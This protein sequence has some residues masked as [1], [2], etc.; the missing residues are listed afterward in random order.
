MAL[1]KRATILRTAIRVNLCEAAIGT[2]GH[3]PI[4]FRRH[5]LPRKTPSPLIAIVAQARLKEVGVSLTVFN[6]RD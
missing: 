1:T 6:H 5:S 3:A 2:K 4:P